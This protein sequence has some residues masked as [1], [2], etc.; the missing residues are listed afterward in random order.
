MLK[1]FFPAG[2]L[3]SNSG[4]RAAFSAAEPV[5]DFLFNARKLKL[6][7]SQTEA[8]CYLFGWRKDFFLKYSCHNKFK[9]HMVGVRC[10]FSGAS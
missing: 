2:C 3:T 6:A 8:I 9:A 1:A 5:V 4:T 7:S 10:A